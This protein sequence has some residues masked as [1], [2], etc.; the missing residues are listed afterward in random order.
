[1]YSGVLRGLGNDDD[2][3]VVFVLTVL[4]DR[5]LV[6]ESLVPPGLRSVLFGSATLE[7][8]VE[9][10][11]REGGGDASEVVFGVLVRVCTDPCN[12]LMPD[13]KMRLRGNT[14][15]VLDLMKKLQV[16]EVQYHR[17]LFLLL[18]SPRL[19]LGCRI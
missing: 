16:T 8:L 13:S 4:R 3:T 9:V 18:L 19:L 15:R 7:Q 6:V 10:C 2:E 1:M 12:G 17:D 11:G 5:V 14:K